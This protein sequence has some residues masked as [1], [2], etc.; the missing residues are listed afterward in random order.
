MGQDQLPKKYGYSDFYFIPNLDLDV[1]RLM[2]LCCSW[3]LFL[4]WGRASGGS[5]EWGGA[6]ETKRENIGS[7]DGE[8]EKKEPCV[9]LESEEG[10]LI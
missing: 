4:F 1:E 5:W 2:R 8:R 7:D 10:A 3:F 9:Q 6:D